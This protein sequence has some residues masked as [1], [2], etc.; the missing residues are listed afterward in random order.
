MQVVRA[1]LAAAALLSAAVPAVA[2]TGAYPSR[3]I[4]LVLPFAAGSGTDTT[5][6]II[7]QKLGQ[8]LYENDKIGT[9]GRGGQDRGGLRAS[10][11]FFNSPDEI[12][13]L[14]GAVGKYLKTGV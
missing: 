4:T 2:D 1:A 11:H 10:P 3:N 5:T 6:R 12:D 14:V 13:R 8:A 9:A 7:S